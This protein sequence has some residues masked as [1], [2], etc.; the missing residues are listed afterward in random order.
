MPPRKG[1]SVR[2]IVVVSDLHCGCRLGLMPLA[3]VP[4]DDG[5]TVHPSNLQ[6]KT[7]AMW[8]EFWD[9]WVPSVTHGEPFALVV[10]GD[11]LEGNHHGSTT[12]VSHNLGDQRKIAY[13][14]LAPEVRKACAYYHVRGTEAHVGQSAVDEEGLAK[15]LGAIPNEEGQHAR[16]E[17]WSRV[18]NSLVHF[19]H[20]IGTTGSSAYE[21]TAVHKELVESFVEAGRWGL[22][23]PRIIVR[24]H[25]HRYFESRISGAGGYFI[26]TVTPAWQLKTPHTYKI[27]GARLSQPQIGGI[28]IR[29]G[30]EELHVRAKTWQIER[31]KAVVL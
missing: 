9:V 10:N 25:R 31:P 30:D 29:Q 12:Q 1:K 3:G 11:A 27:P 7:W 15:D 2:N 4:L 17:L 26:G 13:E 6:R 22:E 20:H 24:S 19:L 21:S 28:V 14:V 18:G 8:R 5:G 23:P 16:W